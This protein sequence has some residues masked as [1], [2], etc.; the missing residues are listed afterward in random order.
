MNSRLGKRDFI[1]YYFD[2]FHGDSSAFKYY[3]E[4]VLLPADVKL[5]ADEFVRI[6]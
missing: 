4:S 5:I 3:V 2:D 6:F 1:L